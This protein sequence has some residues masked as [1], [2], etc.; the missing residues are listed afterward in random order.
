MEA[1][2]GDDEKLEHDMFGDWP[3]SWMLPAPNGTWHPIE[4]E[5]VNKADQNHDEG[6]GA[7]DDWGSP[8]K[9]SKTEDKY[10]D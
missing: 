1:G 4:S 8:G 9:N 5:A 7:R 10:D 2:L 3:K 6:D